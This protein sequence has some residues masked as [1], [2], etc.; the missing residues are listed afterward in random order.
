MRD[1]LKLKK[2]YQ[3]SRIDLFKKLASTNDGFYFNKNHTDLVD[4]VVK[5]IV[6][7]IYNIYPIEDFSLIAV[8]GYGRH[9][10]S[11]KSDVDLLFIYKKS[12]KNIN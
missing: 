12:N 7:G 9:D 3:S 6:K 10:L 1:V 5:E 2:K 4:T 8:G 11:P